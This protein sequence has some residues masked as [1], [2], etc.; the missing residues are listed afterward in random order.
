MRSYSIKRGHKP[1]LNAL[2]KKYFGVEGDV[3][4]GMDFEVEGIGKIHM[5]KEKNSLLIET[6]PVPSKSAS[7][8]IIKRW[9]DFL[10]D[11]TGRTAKERKK[12]MEK[13]MLGK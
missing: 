8:D 3:E 11:A 12:L 1:D 13:E 7:V 5:K 2:I 9:N 6:E 4:K 10:F